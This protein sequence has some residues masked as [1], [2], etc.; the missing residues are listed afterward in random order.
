MLTYNPKDRITAKKAMSHPWFDDLDK[1][2]KDLS[3]IN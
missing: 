2:L 1:T 3:P